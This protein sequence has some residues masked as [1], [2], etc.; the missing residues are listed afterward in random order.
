MKRRLLGVLLLLGCFAATSAEALQETV[1]PPTTLGQW[2]WS[3]RDAELF[4]SSR[5]TFKDLAPGLWAS[6]LS[7]EKGHV[8]QRLALSPT[9]VN[10]GPMAIVVRFDDNLHGAW[11]KIASAELTA[12]INSKLAELLHLL[13]A[14]GADVSEIQLDYDCPVRR[15][16]LWAE[17]LHQLKSSSLQNQKVWITSL[18]SQVRDPRYG[19]LFRASVAGH[20]LQVFDTG[21]SPFRQDP[22]SINALLLQTAMPFQLGFG[23]FERQLPSRQE[24]EHRVWFATLPVFAQNPYFRGLWVFPG[25][26]SWTG[27]LSKKDLG[28]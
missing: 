22:E 27:L 25:G 5:T 19:E 11:D 24:T 3:K 7:F 6:T 9:T 13:Q 4:L 21:D 28:L 15:L 14:N 26:R 20:I 12:E 16:P 18:L 1:A 23:A 2:I 17:T 10:S 8:Q